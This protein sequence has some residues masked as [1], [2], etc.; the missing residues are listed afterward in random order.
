MGPQRAPCNPW[1]PV[2]P[3]RQSDTAPAETTTDHGM[4]GDRTPSER[5]THDKS[6]ALAGRDAAAR[7]VIAAAPA[8]SAAT[9]HI[10][11]CAAPIELD[12][13]L[14]PTSPVP[15][16]HQLAMA[17]EEALT[18]G[19]LLPGDRLESEAALASR[20]GLSRPTVRHATEQ[21]VRKGLLVRRRGVGTQ[22]V[23]AQIDRATR[24]ASIPRIR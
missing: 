20:L 16:Y 18:T 23:R 8:G 15:L 10:R 14:D 13:A 24:L 1:C 17:I 22:V 7:G 2:Q 3:H 9:S 21:L 19:S 5:E 4:P 11:K 6:L 12:V